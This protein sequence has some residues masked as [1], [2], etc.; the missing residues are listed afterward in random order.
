[1]GYQALATAG[2]FA[3]W[4]AASVGVYG[5]LGSIQQVGTG[6]IASM[7][8]INEL[9]RYITDLDTSKAQRQFRDLSKEFNLPIEDVSQ[10]FAQMGRVF[11]NQDQAFEAARGTLT[12]VRVGELEVAD[13]TRFLSAI[14]QGF[15]IPASQ[16]ATVIDQINSAQ[17]NLNFSIRDGTAGIARAA[18]SWRA[19]GGS[20][21]ELLAI[22]ATAQR[23]TGATGEVVGT[24]FR[25]SAEFIGREANQAKL[26]QFGI[27]PTQGVDQVYKQAFD[28]VQS[29]RVKGQDVTRLATALSSPQLAAVIGPT[30]QNVKLYRQ[31]LRDTNAEASH[32]SAQ[33]ELAIQLD[34]VRERVKAIT[35][36]LQQLGSGLAQSG[37]LSGLG[38]MLETLN[39]VLRISNDVLNIFN[40]LPGPVRETVTAVGEIYAVMRLMRRLN[41]GEFLT[42]N[43]ARN[44]GR[45]SQALGSLGGLVTG[46]GSRTRLRELQT[47]LDEELRFY[48][49]YRE[50]IGR[51]GGLVG[52]QTEAAQRRLADY[53]EA[54][55]NFDV[56]PQTEL[57][58]RAAE[59][60]RAREII[61]AQRRIDDLGAEREA[62]LRE[63]L[64]TDEK[65]ATI[66][67][68][69]LEINRRGH[70]NAREGLRYAEQAGIEGAGTVGAP[71][72]GFAPSLERPTTEPVRRASEIAAAA[73]KE[74]A[75]AAVKGGL[76]AGAVAADVEAAHEEVKRAVGKGAS[77]AAER[78]G[79][80][81]GE[82]GNDIVN[83]Q[84]R[85]RRSGAQIA[86]R[87]RGLATGMRTAVGAVAGLFGP[88]ELILAGAIFAPG[89]IE[90]FQRR[91]EQRRQQV[92]RLESHPLT[93]EGQAQQLRAAHRAADERLEQ[94]ERARQQ[95]EDARRNGGS[96]D[97]GTVAAARGLDR[98]PAQQAGIEVI[99]REQERQRRIREARARQQEALRQS[100]RTGLP[101]QLPVI[102][103]QELDAIQGELPASLQKIQRSR[104]P[105]AAAAATFRRFYAEI[106]ASRL[107][108]LAKATDEE[109]S[110]G[111][112]REEV[113]AEARRLN[114]D[115]PRSATKG[116]AAGVIRNAAK[117]R[118]NS[119]ARS[120]RQSIQGFL[121]PTDLSD[122][123]V[124]RSYAEIATEFQQEAATIEA[125]GPSRNRLRRAAI[126]Y[127]QA[128]QHLGDRRDADAIKAITEMNS[129]LSQVLT[130]TAQDAQEGID[131][132]TTQ[133]G[134]AS[135]LNRGIRRLRA[136]PRSLRSQ[137]GDARRDQAEA[138]RNQAQEER[139]LAE[140]Q[141]RARR[142]PRFG[143]RQRLLRLGPL[144]QDADATPAIQD[145]QRD[146]ARAGIQAEAAAARVRGAMRA[147]RSGRDLTAK[148]IRAL[149]NAYLDQNA[150]A[151]AKERLAVAQ[152]GDDQ[153]GAA[154]VHRNF[155]R[156]NLRRAQRL[157]RAGVIDQTALTNARA[158]ALEAQN[159]L[160][161][162]IANGAQDAKD[163]LSL[164][165]SRAALRESALPDSSESGARGA[166]TVAD[167][168]DQLAYAKQH[169][170]DE[171]TINGLQTS[172]NETVRQNAQDAKARAEDARQ[173]TR[174][175]ISA[176]FDYR[177]SLTDNPVRLAKLDEQEAKALGGVG[178][179][180]TSNSR[181]GRRSTRSGGL[182]SRPCATARSRTSTTSTTSRSSPT[183][184]TS[185]AWSAS[186]R[187]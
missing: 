98:T 169:G 184:P 114:K 174:D 125:L 166:Q 100:R 63:G 93:G 159:S 39:G 6:A 126:L 156:G 187:R 73:E 77:E 38:L 106:M 30:L 142:R 70:R 148:Q 136:T 150:L 139:R 84:N 107:G 87:G 37:A 123:D 160:D 47:A 149:G 5:A 124:D 120:L 158:A 167:L 82:A 113:V 176:L 96:V 1:L 14:Y 41:V 71:I 105:Q 65:I 86:A 3:A 103:Y 117:E 42:E 180:A 128:F 141:E 21:S 102:P 112:T 72:Y 122:F 170:L 89:L 91:A 50:D 57:G 59:H 54:P 62:L 108:E 137:L 157:F 143:G 16:T 178:A 76:I 32:G 109:I 104:A 177:R 11:N 2:K 36:E 17:N 66:Q 135:A 111:R 23:S 58:R 153:I 18:G 132:A 48:R 45:R 75:A 35:I 162:E 99:E 101:P 116:E 7:S 64:E 53:H 4:T 15:Q 88:L 144:A 179:T 26:R 74:G 110:G 119:A 172:I 168:N 51:R 80:G 138:E 182:A 22:M 19:A 134:R 69:N 152:Q 29:G 67:E 163:Q 44:P 43:A 133:R 52:V 145:A 9:S 40:A 165:Q 146:V 12:A 130:A 155:S 33:R 92:E 175:S 121:D 131:S 183:T 173:K 90:G 161:Q 147:L 81:L 118:V 56:Y 78:V 140:V 60:D 95:V 46:D 85:V 129:A 25:R 8:G 171:E 185:A 10:A 127:T 79:E 186:S 181:T 31:A 83:A 151:D 28:A 61:S 24:A 97:V 49:N 94:E 154:T 34:A 13:A 27:D 115:L 20:F 55:I 68:R 164:M